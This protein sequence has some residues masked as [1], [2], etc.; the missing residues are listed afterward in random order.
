MPNNTVAEVARIW[1]D[2]GVS[3]IP[4]V[5]GGTKMPAVKW[6]EF[7]TRLPQFLELDHWWGNGQE[8][9][10]ALIMGSI[11]GNVEMLELEGRACDPES[12]MRIETKCAELG[13]LDAW[14]MLLEKTY[15]EESPGGGLHFIYRLHDHPVPGNEKVA[16]RP[17]TLDEL[18]ENP[19]E[20]IKVL[21]ETRGEGG[22]VIV[23][24]TPGICHP[25][26]RQWLKIKG[27]YGHLQPLLWETRCKI[28]QAIRE[29]LDEMPE[30]VV[31]A[32]STS[33]VAA[34]GT[35]MWDDWDRQQHFPA[36]LRERGWQ[37]LGRDGWVRPGKEPRDGVSATLDHDGTGR[38]YVFST[39]AEIDSGRY[40]SPFE[41]VAYADFGGDI[42]SAL[43]KLNI[44]EDIAPIKTFTYVQDVAPE[45]LF[46][47]FSDAGNAQRLADRD[48]VRGLFHWVHEEKAYRCWTGKKWEED[49]TGALTREVMD[50]GADMARADDEA[51]AK[52]GK[53]TRANS[54]IQASM[55]LFQSILGVTKHT[56][57]FD[58]DLELLNVDNGTL[59]L[60]TGNLHAHNS[61]NLITR[62]FNAVYD[63]MA[64]CP[65]WERFVATMIP[66]PEIRAYVQRS[67]GYSL[68]GASDQRALFILHGPTGTG[69]STFLETMRMLFGEYGATAPAGAFRNRGRETGAT[70][71]LHSLRGKRFV[72][73]SETAESTA[74]DEELLKRLTG[75][76]TVT[77][78]NLYELPQEWTPE[79]TI[80]LATNFPPKFNSDDDAI[81]KRAKMIHLTHQFIGA[82]EIP[83]MARRFM[84]PEASGI[85]N[86]LLAGLREHLAHGAGEPAAV[87]D[88]VSQ[89]RTSVEPVSRFISDMTESGTL[90]IEATATIRVSDL[91]GLFVAWCREN[92]ERGIGP[93]RFGNRMETL[94]GDR[95]YT[96][97]HCYVGIKRVPMAV[98]L[99]Q[100]FP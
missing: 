2:A 90:A 89:Y 61:S 63:P 94:F 7:Q 58:Q 3:T 76:D 65:T 53:A 10:L 62:T 20:R 99:F 75:R 35:H 48:S 26:G 33:M 8:Y 51:T 66:D 98:P 55:K 73:S 60:R 5:P 19:S 43:R 29:A 84:M 41:F 45:P 56:K 27:M 92:G 34:P 96:D 67:L 14:L 12:L 88:H 100:R 50:M 37:P 6:S 40:Y 32:P 91:H 21:A 83:D 71:E 44:K 64:T 59:D 69:K 11:S 77:S 57:D 78:R 95:I 15:Q 85:L 28:H 16:R 80:W 23:A 42:K 68:M 70:S 97:T 47:D 82:G 17:A 79:A 1:H 18:S 38:L 46:Y 81:W 72:T 39:S 9:G 93:R 86:W 49:A 22:Y 36:L 54:R 24:P 74:F 52:W 30:P 4:I 13:C 31:H 87:T 25:S